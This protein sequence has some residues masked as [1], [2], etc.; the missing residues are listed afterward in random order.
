VTGAGAEAD[1]E[2]RGQGGAGQERRL[3]LWEGLG[4]GLVE[5]LRLRTRQRLWAWRLGGLTLRRCAT[6]RP[7]DE[8][9]LRHPSGQRGVQL[10]D[11]TMVCVSAP[12]RAAFRNARHARNVRRAGTSKN[13][14]TS[15]KQGEVLRQTFSAWP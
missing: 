5:R 13:R 12:N 10:D 7:T 11:P 6:W 9:P 3:I 4:L 2:A 15:Q 1:G 14:N 8:R